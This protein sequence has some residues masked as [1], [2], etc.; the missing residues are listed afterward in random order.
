[1]FK[2]N[3]K[4]HHKVKDVSLGTVAQPVNYLNIR[5]LFAIPILE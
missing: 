5:I 1:L 3:E 2:L 4:L